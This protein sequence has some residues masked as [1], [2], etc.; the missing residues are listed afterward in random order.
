MSPRV[1]H[2]RD[3]N[4]YERCVGFP[5]TIRLWRS[6]SQIWKT[7]LF[8]DRDQCY[9][10][11]NGKHSLCGYEQIFI[12][13]PTDRTFR[14]FRDAGQRFTMTGYHCR[15]GGKPLYVI[16]INRNRDAKVLISSVRPMR[17][18]G[19]IANLKSTIYPSLSSIIE[20]RLHIPVNRSRRPV[21]NSNFALCLGYNF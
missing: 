16:L 14:G 13:S 21:L 18:G 10:T 7:S 6:I 4:C 20:K 17:F 1:F 12:R 3:I 11:T 8:R 2:Q 9:S 15:F 19:L 5:T